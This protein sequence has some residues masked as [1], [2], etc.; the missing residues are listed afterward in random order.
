MR[1][2]AEQDRWEDVSLLQGAA[3]VEALKRQKRR[4][5]QMQAQVN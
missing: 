4:K 2:V 3:A 1:D 5:A